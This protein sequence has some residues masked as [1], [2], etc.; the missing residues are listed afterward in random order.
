VHEFALRCQRERINLWPSKGSPQAMD[1]DFRIFTLGANTAMPGMKYIMVDTVRSQL[2]IE[3]E[4][5]KEA[6]DEVRYSLFAGSL[7]E[8][9]DFLQQLLNDSAVDE[10][11]S[12]N[13]V[14]QSWERVTDSIPND[15]RDCR[16]YSYVAMLAASQGGNIRPRNYAPPKEDA[17]PSRFRP[18]RIRR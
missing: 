7:D 4:L 3:D 17:E 16:R 12:S 11:D 8:H 13:N 15:F 14:R 9:R 2:W 18:L 10:L 1:S 6:A 5:T